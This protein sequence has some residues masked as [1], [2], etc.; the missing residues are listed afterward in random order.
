MSLDSSILVCGFTKMLVL[1]NYLSF[2]FSTD[3]LS[4]ATYFV[5]FVDFMFYFTSLIFDAKF[6]FIFVYSEAKNSSP[7]ANFILPIFFA[8]HSLTSEIP[9]FKSFSKRLN[10]DLID[11]F[12]FSGTYPFSSYFFSTNFPIQLIMFTFIFGALSPSPYFTSSKTS[13]IEILYIKSFKVLNV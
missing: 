4:F 2:V 11:S 6:L 1:P 3:F 9:S 8:M 5:S 13:S 10:K 12:A 7:R